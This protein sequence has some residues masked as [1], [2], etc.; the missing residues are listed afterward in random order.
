MCPLSP[1]LG[2]RLSEQMKACGAA[3]EW[4]QALK[5]FQE[6]QDIGI[7]PTEQCFTA[8]IRA[9]AKA[10]KVSHRTSRFPFPSSGQDDAAP[11]EEGG[12]A[13][14][15][16]YPSVSSKFPAFSVESFFC[17]NASGSP[18]SSFT[19]SPDLVFLPRPD[20]AATAA[21]ACGRPQRRRRCCSRCAQ[22]GASR[23]TCRATER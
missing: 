20:R 4:E 21:A 13:V 9:C 8:A 6:M 5:L 22:R 23:R 16:S 14:V 12:S 19:T 11:Q 10:D 7:P 15:D 17:Q 18:R 2:C 3:G 1:Q